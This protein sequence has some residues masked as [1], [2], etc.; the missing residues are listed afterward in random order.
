MRFVRAI[1][2]RTERVLVFQ[3]TRQWAIPHQNY[4][5][6]VPEDIWY[7]MGRMALYARWYRLRTFWNFG[8]CLHGPLQIRPALAVPG[9]LDQQ[10]KREAPRLPQPGT[11]SGSWGA[12]RPARSC[13]QD[14]RSYVKRPLPWA[15][16]AAV[17]RI[18]G[19]NGGV[20]QM[21][22]ARASDKTAVAR[23]V[24]ARCDWMEARGLPSWRGARD[25][26]VDQCDQPRGDVWVLD[27]G[28]AG[29]IGQT[30]VQR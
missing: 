11:S 29:V 16:Q 10:G 6:P 26:L 30:V 1:A 25:D 20:L 12:N 4:H 23:V 27:D 5:R 13:A 8:D 18:R 15:M 17:G 2:G 14:Y 28:A 21:R 24:D 7:L 22:L 19:H 9:S 3:R